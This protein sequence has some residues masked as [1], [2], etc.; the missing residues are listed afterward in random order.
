MSVDAEHNAR[1]QGEKFLPLFS[2]NVAA[3]TQFPS[4]LV[5]ML[6]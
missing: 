5:G 1:W 3:R 6:V 4:N 2:L